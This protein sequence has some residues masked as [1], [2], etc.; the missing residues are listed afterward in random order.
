MRASLPLTFSLPSSPPCGAHAAVATTYLQP[1]SKRLMPVTGQVQFL[2][3]P[4]H[5]KAVILQV[6]PLLRP[7]SGLLSRPL[8]GPYRAAVVPHVPLPSHPTAPH[9]PRHPH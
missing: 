4:D 6:R 2:V 8:F 1:Y 7:L 9:L 5:T 3:S